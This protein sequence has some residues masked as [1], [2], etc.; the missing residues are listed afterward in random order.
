[1]ERITVNELFSGIGAQ[2]K[3]LENIGVEH[4]VV[5]ISDIDKYANQSYN[6]FHKAKNSGVSNTQL[7]RQAGKSI[8]VKVL[9]RIFE[10]LLKE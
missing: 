8:V 3:A 2:R 5:G 4:E 1:M 6:A 10:N 7:Y 9:E